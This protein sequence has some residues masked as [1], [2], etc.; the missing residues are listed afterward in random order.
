M[1]RV[2]DIQYKFNMHS[3]IMRVVNFYLKSKYLA[4]IHLVRRNSTIIGHCLGVHLFCDVLA[5][6]IAHR[7]ELASMLANWRDSV[8]AT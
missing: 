4:T 8:N 6:N 7:T 1:A 3:L 5:V 2:P